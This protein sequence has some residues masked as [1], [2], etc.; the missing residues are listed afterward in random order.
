[1]IERAALCEAT[2][3]SPSTKHVQRFNRDG[4]DA[5][6]R[7]GAVVPHADVGPECELAAMG[8]PYISVHAGRLYFSAMRA[9]GEMDAKIPHGPVA[10]FA[11]PPFVDEVVEKLAACPLDV[12]ALAF[13]SSAYKHGSEGELQLLTRLSPMARNL[14]MTT[15]CIAAAT[16][17]R[18]LDARRIALVNPPWFDQGLDQAGADY[19]AAQGFHVIHHAPCGLP[20]GQRHITPIGLFE[21]IEG[22]SAKHQPDVIF[23]AG[24]GQ[25]AVGIIEAVENELDVTL[26]T[27][28]QLILWH[29]LKLL[30]RRPP[31]RGY[32]RIFDAL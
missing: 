30:G 22:M 23:V 15:T 10:S 6:I 11:E 26:V 12:I 20:S 1:M 19:F 18:T 21:W 24:N 5:D 28:N 27:A 7:F 31:I 14:P 29:G 13:T 3:A 4:W 8:S 2:E 32:G 17:F 9:G 25:R 16:A